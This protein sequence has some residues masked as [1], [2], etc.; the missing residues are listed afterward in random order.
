MNVKL[1]DI[2]LVAAHGWDVAGALRAGARAAFLSR[3]GQALYP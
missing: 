2:M 3:P 1:E